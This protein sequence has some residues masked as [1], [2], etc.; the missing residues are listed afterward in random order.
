MTLRIDKWVSWYS[1]DDKIN[2]AYLTVFED[3][4][5][6]KLGVQGKLHAIEVCDSLGIIRGDYIYGP[7]F[8]YDKN[9]RLRLDYK[10]FDDHWEVVVRYN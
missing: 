10:K 4:L 8:I 7:V 6:N 2:E 3:Y 9:L 5:N 1:H